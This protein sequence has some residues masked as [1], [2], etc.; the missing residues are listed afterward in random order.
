MALLATSHLLSLKI[1][2]SHEGFKKNTSLGQMNSQTNRQTSNE[3]HRERTR[4]Q[5]DVLVRL[6]SNVHKRS[7][8]S[9]MTVKSDSFVK[10]RFGQFSSSRGTNEHPQVGEKEIKDGFPQDSIL[11]KI[12]FGSSF[13]KKQVGKQTKALTHRVRL[14]D[15]ER[16]GGSLNTNNSKGESQ[17]RII[18]GS[19]D[20][21]ALRIDNETKRSGSNLFQGGN[22]AIE[23]SRASRLGESY[24]KINFVIVK[25][26]ENALLTQARINKSKRNLASLQRERKDTKCKLS[27]YLKV[28]LEVV[29]TFLAENKGFLEECE[30]SKS[31]TIKLVVC[32]ANQ[33]LVCLQKTFSTQKLIENYFIIHHVHQ[34][35]N[36]LD[37]SEDKIEQLKL[38]MRGFLLRV[39]M[40]SFEIWPN[41]VETFEKLSEL[42]N[43][44]REFLDASNYYKVRGFE[45]IC[46]IY[47]FLYYKISVSVEEM[48]TTLQRINKEEKEEVLKNQ[49][50]TDSPALKAYRHQRS[51]KIRE[52]KDQESSEEEQECEEANTAIYT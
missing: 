24:S 51:E 44:R 30:I 7:K 17:K 45:G 47:M 35:K 21:S 2:M 52:K 25:D 1:K 40:G 49:T 22:G 10:N 8:Q 26:T 6:D 43:E 38:K 31:V 27:R 19:G 41:N 16:G 14:M 4:G 20:L 18:M 33:E 9:H 28:R 50:S 5:E 48:E 12:Q 3:D 13:Y 15:S 46:L 42:V 39:V 29:K 11:P 34:E 32:F 23:Q 36:E 37:N